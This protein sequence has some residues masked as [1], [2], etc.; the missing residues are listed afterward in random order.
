MLSAGMSEAL[1]V[2]V[3]GGRDFADASLVERALSAVHR[4]H[5]IAV[6][7]EGEATGAD[8]LSKLWAERNGV[9]VAPYPAKWTD[10]SHPDAVIRKRR[11]GT[12]YDAKAGGRRNQQ[13][14]EHG[15]PSVAVAF[16]GGTG[17]ADMVR[18]LKKAAIPVWDL[19]A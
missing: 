12:Q 16:P 11:D 15:K 9:E 19:G 5:G 6:L 2:V 8:T 10:L 18:K 3:T 4:K 17:T 7:I 1:R 14:I 13:M